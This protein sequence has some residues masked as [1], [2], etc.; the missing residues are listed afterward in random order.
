LLLRSSTLNS[1]Q[2]L[3]V[4]FSF[5]KSDR[6]ERLSS[7]GGS[8]AIALKGDRIRNLREIAIA[9]PNEFIFDTRK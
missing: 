6:W 3:S 9:S 4:I 5:A 7:T 8:I 2:E 1:E